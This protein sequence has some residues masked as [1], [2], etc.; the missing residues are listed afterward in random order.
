MTGS[1]LLN[2]LNGM[3]TAIRSD[4]PSDHRDERSWFQHLHI[5]LQLLETF[6]EMEVNED[7]DDVLLHLTSIGK[8]V[9]SQEVEQSIAEEA[10]WEIGLLRSEIERMA[11][12]ID[13]LVKG[14]R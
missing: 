12:Q 5:K 8:G 1:R 3:A 13:R 7:E 2:L 4:F 6:D 11:H 10:A 14:D 9:L